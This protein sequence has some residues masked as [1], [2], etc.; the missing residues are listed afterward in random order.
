MAN[1]WACTVLHSRGRVWAVVRPP[2]PPIAY[3]D[4][5]KVR[6]I[7]N[8]LISDRETK[9]PS[10]A[11]SQ[12][13]NSATCWHLCQTPTIQ[14]K[15]KLCCS[16]IKKKKRNVGKSTINDRSRTDWRSQ[17][18]ELLHGQTG[19]WIL[20]LIDL[21]VTR[22]ETFELLFK[23]SHGS[24]LSHAADAGQVTSLNCTSNTAV[25]L[26]LSKAPMPLSWFCPNKNRT[27]VSRTKELLYT[28][29]TGNIV[30]D[31]ASRGSVLPFISAIHHSR[32]VTESNSHS[33]ARCAFDNIPVPEQ[34]Q[35]NHFNSQRIAYYIEKRETKSSA[36]LLLPQVS[37]SII[38]NW[39]R[40]CTGK[41]V[42]LSETFFIQICHSI[43]I[44]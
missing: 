37:F 23:P 11:Y 12:K 26:L 17:V 29:H 5:Y 25:A 2:P 15:L 33:T 31:S 27:F 22:V 39:I 18:S 24:P 32:C 42:R 43:N 35:M 34:Q 44:W 36:G 16:A 14:E 13:G 6:R 3:F 10:R 1:F 4:V 30:N 21:H 40:I 41:W 8:A 38:N 20:H 19:L 7:I 9:E 28:A